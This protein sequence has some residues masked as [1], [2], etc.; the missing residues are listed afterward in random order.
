ML[1]F[2]SDTGLELMMNTVTL[3]CLTVTEHKIPQGYSVNSCH[4]IRHC[5]SNSKRDNSFSID[6]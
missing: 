4:K 6:Y 2:I 5:T 3:C 1:F